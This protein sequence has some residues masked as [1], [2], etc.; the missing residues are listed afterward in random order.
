MG[1]KAL[2]TT[3]KVHL[4]YSREQHLG[5]AYSIKGIFLGLEKVPTEATVPGHHLVFCYGNS[6]F[7][8]CLEIPWQKWRRYQL[9]WLLFCTLRSGSPKRRGL[10]GPVWKHTWV[11]WAMTESTRG[12]RKPENMGSLGKPGKSTSMKTRSFPTLPAWYAGAGRMEQITW[13]CQQA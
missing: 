4:Y 13:L 6:P 3:L 9:L 10:Q 1:F 12:C 2:P 5:G 11:T 8:T 7:G